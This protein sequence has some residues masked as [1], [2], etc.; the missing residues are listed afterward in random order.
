MTAGNLKTYTHKHGGGG[1]VNRTA[2][3]KHY[4]ATGGGGGGAT[5]NANANVTNNTSTLISFNEKSEVQEFYKEGK[6]LITGSTG[7]IGKALTEKLLR[8]CVTVSTIY[9]LIR[10][11][12]GQ[13]EEERCQDLLQNPVSGGALKGTAGLTE[14]DNSVLFFFFSV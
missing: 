5:T 9:L 1:D 14:R 2:I 8:T 7:F 13:N 10:P 12:R 11:K 3:W 6:V 4:N